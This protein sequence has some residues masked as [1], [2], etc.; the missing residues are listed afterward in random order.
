[1]QFDFT[2]IY[3]TGN[4]VHLEPGRYKVS[5]KDNWSISRND[6]GNLN[7]RVPFIVMDEG[8]FNGASSSFYHTIVQ[9]PA[10]YNTLPP[11]DKAEWA[12]KLRKNKVFTLRLFS[13]LG[14]IT[15]ADRGENGQVQAAFQYGEEDEYAR[16][17]ITGL[18][19]NGTVRNLDNLPAVAVVVTS[20][21][22]TSGVKVDSLEP[23]GDPTANGKA[24]PAPSG[25]S[26]SSTPQP[27]TS[28]QGE[29]VFGGTAQAPY[30]GG[31]SQEDIPF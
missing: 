7:V 26:A 15:D 9:P 31:V 29:Q 28:A 22:T 21:Y 4:D 6:K 14:L 8:E 27:A 2:G 12:D 20:S 23:L 30:G 24:A 1:M 10:N 18:N 13:A 25:L 5:T 11:K 19:V 3:D 16:T 17:P